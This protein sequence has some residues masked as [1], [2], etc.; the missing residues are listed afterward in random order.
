MPLIPDQ[1]LHA[2]MNSHPASSLASGSGNTY[3]LKVLDSRAG[4]GYAAGSL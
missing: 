2:D 4:L 1:T 3:R